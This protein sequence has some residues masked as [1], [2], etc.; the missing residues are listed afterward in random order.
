MFSPREFKPNN[1]QTSKSK[2]ESNKFIK[3]SQSQKNLFQGSQLNI[4]TPKYMI[5]GKESTR[6]IL[7]PANK[8]LSSQEQPRKPRILNKTR[9]SAS[10]SE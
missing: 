9:H 8:N 4:T 2:Y 3:S 7:T 6:N 1:Y 10:F 5:A